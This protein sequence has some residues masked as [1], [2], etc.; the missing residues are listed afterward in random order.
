MI[1]ADHYSTLI[2]ALLKAI[3]M[4]RGPVLELGTG[5]FTTP[6]LHWLCSCRLR[7]VVSLENNPNWIAIAR[8]FLMPGGHEVKLVTNWDRPEYLEEWGLAVVDNDP[9]ITRR[10]IAPLLAKKTQL[11]LL[12]DTS[13][14]QDRAFQFD[15]VWPHFRYVF[16]YWDAFPGTSLLSNFIDLDGLDIWE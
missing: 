16:H 9:A 15:S 11:V 10:N 3:R 1:R 2:P 4:T 6:I 7:N 14:E 5:Y 8:Q 13:P 12:H